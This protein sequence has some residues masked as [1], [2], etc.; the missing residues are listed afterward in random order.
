MLG[1]RGRLAGGGHWARGTHAAAPQEARTN[2]PTMIVAVEGADFLEGALAPLE[3]A[4]RDHRLRQLQLT[5]YRV[6]ELG[7]I[8]TL[9]PVH[10]GLTAF[11]ADVI[12]AC[13]RLGI[14]VDVA[15][16]TYELVK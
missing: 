4:H 1:A 5:H 7:D 13:N 12:R 16:G 10:G 6:N 9:P 11:G 8:Q 14:V 2:G 3:A 15:H